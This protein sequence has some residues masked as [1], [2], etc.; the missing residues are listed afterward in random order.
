VQLLR[1]DGHGT[2]TPGSAVMVG[3]RPVALAAADFDG[4]GHLDLAIADET[5]QSL[6]V[7]LGDGT[8]GFTPGSGLPPMPTVAALATGDLDGDGLPDLVAA[9]P[10]DR[11]IHV[12]LDR[13]GK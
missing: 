9:A 2:L 10:I 13:S 6:R 5:E 1:N 4:D 12:L 11:A 3:P 8:G 7:L